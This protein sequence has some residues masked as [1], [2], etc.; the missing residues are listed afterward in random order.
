MELP[1]GADDA[2]TVL[3]PVV[4]CMW[5]SRDVT[6]KDR[7]STTSLCYAPVWQRDLG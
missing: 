2:S 5:V 3:V 7:L 1:G 6:L 4:D